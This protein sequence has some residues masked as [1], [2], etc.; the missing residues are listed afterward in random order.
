MEAASFHHRGPAVTVRSANRVRLCPTLRRP[1]VERWVVAMI[2]VA[3]HE[4][5]DAIH[6]LPIYTDVVH[7]PLPRSPESH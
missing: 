1:S 3:V 7:V 4:T 5:P 2:L 6:A